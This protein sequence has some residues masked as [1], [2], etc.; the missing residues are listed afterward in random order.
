MSLAAPPDPARLKA[1]PQQPLYGGTMTEQTRA[2]DLE[3]FDQGWRAVLKQSPPATLV[4]ALGGLTRLG[5]HPA[6]LGQLATILDRPPEETVALLRA[7]TTARIEDG[8]VHWDDPFPGGRTLRTLYVGD[9]EIPMKRGCAPDLPAY[10]AVVDVPF[11]VEDT[12]AATGTPIRISF[13]PDGY[14]RADPPETVAMFVPIG[15]PGDAPFE[16]LQEIE[17]NVCVRQPFFASAR[18]AQNWLAATPGAR[19]FTI[20]EMFERPAYTYYRDN[21]RPLMHPELH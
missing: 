12:C 4:T 16:S 1:Y 18:A 19:V 6:S 5:E 9:R 2:D 15:R 14:E 11:R 7:N 17:A 20:K 13:V 8:L 3:E 10:A 21:L